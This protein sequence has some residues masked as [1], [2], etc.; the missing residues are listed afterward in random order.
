MKWS[1][2]LIIGEGRAHRELP[3][4]GQWKSAGCHLWEE[5]RPETS[6]VVIRGEHRH[7]FLNPGLR[8]GSNEQKGNYSLLSFGSNFALAGFTLWGVSASYSWKNQEEV[9]FREDCGH[10]GSSTLSSE[11]VL[12]FNFWKPPREKQ[13]CW[14]IPV[15]GAW[16]LGK[17]N[18]WDAYW[19]LPDSQT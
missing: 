18:N 9:M 15:K 17:L 5:L 12:D 4:S 11:E 8:N 13:N 19:S 1:V 14:T 16:V 3:K 10:V 2:F 6:V 7:S